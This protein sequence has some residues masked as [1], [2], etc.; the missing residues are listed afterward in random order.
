MHE[1]QPCTH[2]GDHEKLLRDALEDRIRMHWPV[3]GTVVLCLR[4]RM[5]LP[6]ELAA[7]LA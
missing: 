6:L 1:V 5:K 3:E 4:C 2:G 7:S